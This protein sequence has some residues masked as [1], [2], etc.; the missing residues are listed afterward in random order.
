[1][2]SGRGGNPGRRGSKSE[3]WKG[4]QGLRKYVDG[5]RVTWV[6]IG[7]DGKAEEE[8]CLH[9]G[10]FREGQVFGRYVGIP[11]VHI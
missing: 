5:I 4:S 2:F 11:N 9:G 7:S 6:P 10:G 3:T 1:M 8:G